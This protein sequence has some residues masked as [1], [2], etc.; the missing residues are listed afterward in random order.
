M[1]FVIDANAV[2]SALLKDGKSRQIIVSGTFT[3]I[4]PEFLSEELYKYRRY[5][6]DKAAGMKIILFSKKKIN[7]ADKKTT[8]FIELPRLIARLS[9]TRL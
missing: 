4:A 7:E 2:I 5:I 3:L 9:S 1:M 8:K 6:A